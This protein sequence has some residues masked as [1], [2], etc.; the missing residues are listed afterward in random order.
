[1]NEKKRRQRYAAGKR[2]EGTIIFKHA[3]DPIPHNRL[4]AVYAERKDNDRVAQ[5]KG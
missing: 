4:Y 5:F 2:P 1:L 3:H